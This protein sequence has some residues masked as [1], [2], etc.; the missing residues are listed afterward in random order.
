MNNLYYGGYRGD[1]GQ[2]V[3][4]QSIT[5]SH[6]AS[7]SVL[8]PSKDQSGQLGH[9]SAFPP[10]NTLNGSVRHANVSNASIPFSTQPWSSDLPAASTQPQQHQLHSHHHSLGIPQQDPAS[11]G[12]PST[13]P[14]RQSGLGLG[15]GT[16]S[17]L[18]LPSRPS[19]YDDSM[20]HMINKG[21]AETSTTGNGPLSTHPDPV[22]TRS[23]QQQQQQQSQSDVYTRHT[24]IG[25]SSAVFDPNDFPSLGAGNSNPAASSNA[26][27]NSGLNSGSVGFDNLSASFKSSM[28]NTMNGL[29]P[30]SD[31]Y[32]FNAY[33][34]T[35]SKAA[36]DALTG[37]GPSPEFSMS[38]EDF[39]VLGGGPADVNAGRSSSNANATQPSDTALRNPGR[40]IGME[41]TATGS[42]S[43]MYY[44]V[45]SQ[46]SR[47]QYASGSTSLLPQP[48]LGS[49]STPLPLPL[50]TTGQYGL[51][52]AKQQVPNFLH[53]EQL[54]S[55]G[56]SP[57]DD[58]TH[59][60]TG[61]NLERH[62]LN[63]SGQ[64]LL[65]SSTQ[66][67][68]GAYLNYGPRERLNLGGYSTTDGPN[69][70][71]NTAT[72]D[73]I[74]KMTNDTLNAFQN[75]S[76]DQSRRERLQTQVPPS[77]SA[78]PQ[79]STKGDTSEKGS[80]ASRHPSRE[81]E[82]G[83]SADMD[84]YGMRG[85]L[86]VLNPP[87]G[88]TGDVSL[89]SLG[90]DLTQL[91]LDLNSTDPLIDSFDSPWD[92]YRK[93]V[94]QGAQVGEESN[95]K[96]PSCYYMSPPALKASHFGRF[97]LET[98]FYIFYS[99]PQD[100]LQALAAVELHNRQWRYHKELKLWF[101][102]APGSEATYDRGA[103][104]YFDISSWERRP[105]HDAN[106]QFVQGLM[107]EEELRTIQ[108]T[109]SGA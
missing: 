102:R 18:Q 75:L 96:L 17:R 12:Y 14:L 104:I 66:P 9:S 77:S 63:S 82:N 26:N 79:L 41:R 53:Q 28:P 90:M 99:L 61:Q 10:V 74:A 3:P 80:N 50:S 5:S 76:I 43:D 84:K 22:L 48:T 56:Q 29:N 107:S 20:Y 68:G 34:N 78:V 88:K 94:E 58:V 47:G 93:R 62:M 39:P 23:L 108:P 70:D 60:S 27:S 35:R 13:Q 97:Q 73:G 46:S 105:F 49:S 4:P 36:V 103:Y 106:M 38:T 15:A 2:R 87:P 54:R 91:G 51:S 57:N 55:L 32:A 11:T 64:G 100:L 89:L 72:R 25:G 8:A 52:K 37:T 42:N 71:G 1:P 21:F 95:F 109:T 81:D 44:N 85:L 65:D 59:L 19:P 24:Q 30:Y 83:P 31:L 92:D 33:S 40:V 16:G 6:S 67:L 98:L 69:F 7:Q 101:T 86:R 45:H